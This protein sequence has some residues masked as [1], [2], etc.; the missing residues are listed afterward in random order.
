MLLS[1]GAWGHAPVN[2]HVLT[3]QTQQCWKRNT[4][5][6]VICDNEYNRRDESKG[7]YQWIIIAGVIEIV[8]KEQKALGGL[9]ITLSEFWKGNPNKIIKGCIDSHQWR[10]EQWIPTIQTFHRMIFELFNFWSCL[11]A[12]KDI[13]LSY[14][15]NWRS[16]QFK[17]NR[18]S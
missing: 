6:D 16:E 13:F 9:V 12:K 11:H 4:Y 17:K 3:I 10:S 2:M 18:W 8:I 14:L 1:I 5:D 15:T 7:L